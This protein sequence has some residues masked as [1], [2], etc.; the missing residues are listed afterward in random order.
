MPLSKRRS[1][2]ILGRMADREPGLNEVAY[3]LNCIDGVQG[4]SHE[5]WSR[6]GG[7]CGQN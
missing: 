3:F 5:Y 1:N 4:E 2:G 6:K 7:K